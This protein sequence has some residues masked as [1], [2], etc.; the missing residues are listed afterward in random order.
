MAGA[1]CDREESHRMDP[2][3]TPVRSAGRMEAKATGAGGCKCNAEADEQALAC[4][5]RSRSRSPRL[6]QRGR[7]PL[8]RACGLGWWWWTPAPGWPPAEGGGWVRSHRSSLKHGLCSASRG[9]GVCGVRPMVGARRLGL[10]PVEARAAAPP[11]R[12]SRER[13]GQ[14]S[15]NGLFSSFVGLEHSCGSA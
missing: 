1:V 13:R 10:G 7:Q 12:P 14:P 9:L 6:P 15:A 11:E 5:F 4:C 2:V 8:Q 3:A